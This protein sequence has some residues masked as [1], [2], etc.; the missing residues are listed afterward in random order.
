MVVLILL[1][2]LAIVLLP[3]AGVDPGAVAQGDADEFQYV[4]RSLIGPMASIYLL[5]AL[6]FLLCL[7]VGAVDQGMWA[8]SSLGGWA[9][10]SLI[11][12]GLAPSAAIIGGAIVGSAIGLIHG[13]V[14][15]MFRLP[16]ALVTLVSAGV[17]V[18]VMSMQGTDRVTVSGKVF[19]GW[20]MTVV[21]DQQQ[22]AD[23]EDAPPATVRVEH[24]QPLYVTRMMLVIA[25]YSVVL[26]AMMLG[27]MIAP[28]WALA[29]RR[30]LLAAA[31][32]VSGALSGAAG[33]LWLLDH[34]AAPMASRPIDNLLPVSAAVLAGGLMLAGKGRSLLAGV[35]LPFAMLL[36]TIWQA[37][38]LH[39]Q[40]FG[41]SLQTLMLIVMTL[42]TFAAAKGFSNGRGGHL[43]VA[44]WALCAFGMILLGS[45]PSLAGHGRTMLEAFGVGAW[46]LGAIGA[47]VFVRRP[48]EAQEQDVDPV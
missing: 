26:G 43:L 25:I 9:A 16:S 28:G 38:I 1:A 23:D 15:C 11:N 20:H 39:I 47:A 45:S 41:Y 12:R 44:C 17:I 5:M 32:V 37:N 33:G 4:F 31:L 22:E 34:N 3:L 7:R 8:V 36:A 21:V 46:A 48:H 24:S 29:Y 2:G 6:G 19:E 27:E 35:L 42:F 30:G 13:A 18:L 14:T 10:A 40:R